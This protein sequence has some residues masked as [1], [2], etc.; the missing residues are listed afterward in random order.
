MDCSPPGCSVHG[1]LQARI[2]EWVA[3]PAYGGSSPPQD[4]THVSF[5]SCIGRWVLYHWATWE[6]LDDA[7]GW[8]QWIVTLGTSMGLRIL[9][10]KLDRWLWH[11]HGQYCSLLLFKN[12]YEDL[13]FLMF[14][15]ALKSVWLNCAFE[16]MCVC[17]CILLGICFYIFTDVYFNVCQVGRCL[18]LLACVRGLV[19]FFNHLL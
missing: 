6:A 15:S 13:F 10:S 1:I 9:C 11:L 3:V 2:L 16:Y 18:S 12:N 4:W 14:S 8:S 7:N 19:K 5:I 17:A